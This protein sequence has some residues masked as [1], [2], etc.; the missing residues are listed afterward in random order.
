MTLESM[1]PG[2]SGADS[3]AVHAG[4]RSIRGRLLAQDAVQQVL[5]LRL[6]GELGSQV[7]QPSVRLRSIPQFSALGRIRLQRASLIGE[8]HGI[9]RLLVLARFLAVILPRVMRLPVQL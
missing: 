1:A 4:D 3:A 5:E 6:L 7:R 2:M 9:P 8:R